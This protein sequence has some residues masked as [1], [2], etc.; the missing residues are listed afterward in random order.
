VTAPPKGSVLPGVL[1]GPPFFRGDD[2]VL[3]LDADDRWAMVGPPRRDDPRIL[4]RS[5]VLP[6]GELEALLGQARAMGVPAE[7]V[8]PTP[9]R[10]APTR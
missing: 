5:P 2:G 4:S 1:R 6:A 10:A 3:A 7:R 9:R 8:E